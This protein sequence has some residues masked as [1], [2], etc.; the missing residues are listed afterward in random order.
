[1]SPVLAEHEIQIIQQGR[2]ERLTATERSQ[3]IRS[4]A[5]STDASTDVP[6]TRR[7]SLLHAWT[8]LRGVVT[9][10]VRAGY[11]PIGTSVERT[12]AQS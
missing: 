9:I 8:M 11:R 1:M 10:V 4:L 7:R 3:L 2:R 6:A 12:A 5:A